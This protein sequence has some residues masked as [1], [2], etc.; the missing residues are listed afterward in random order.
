MKKARL[1]LLF[2]VVKTFDVRPIQF[3]LSGDSVEFR[4]EILRQCSSGGLYTARVW[5]KELYRIQPSFPQA[6]GR[7]QHHA[8]DEMIMVEDNLIVWP[9]AKGI[10]GKSVKSVVKQVL[11]ELSKNA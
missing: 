9:G 11:L 1:K 10:S 7:P 3:S 6:R 4:I 8:S 5:R 2:E